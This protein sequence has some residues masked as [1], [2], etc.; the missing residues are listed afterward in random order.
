MHASPVSHP[1]FWSFFGPAFIIMLL[2]WTTVDADAAPVRK[3]A[4]A[5]AP[6]AKKAPAKKTPTVNNSKNKK[7]TASAKKSKGKKAKHHKKHRKHGKAKSRR[8]GSSGGLVSQ[9][10]RDEARLE[11]DLSRLRKLL[12]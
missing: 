2:A 7:K 3:P 4:P 8:S 5:K 6:A 10:R 9:I 12:R 11:A 1:W